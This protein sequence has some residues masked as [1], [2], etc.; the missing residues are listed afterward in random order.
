MK[1]R[2][3]LHPSRLWSRFNL[4][5]LQN[6]LDL[7]IFLPVVNK[8]SKDIIPSRNNRFSR[9][10]VSEKKKRLQSW[11]DNKFWCFS[12]SCDEPP[13]I[14]FSSCDLCTFLTRFLWTRIDCFV[15]E[16]SSLEPAETRNLESSSRWSDVRPLLR[17]PDVQMKW[18]IN[19][20]EGHESLPC[21]IKNDFVFWKRQR[22]ENC[23]K[24]LR[25]LEI[26]SNV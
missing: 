21:S 16:L 24:E 4:N 10:N 20:H 17:V 18:P 23:C 25:S 9:F 5:I 15:F 7:F 3:C 14:L 6:S 2:S 1:L 11:S 26:L 8:P 13:F 19:E 22:K 12:I